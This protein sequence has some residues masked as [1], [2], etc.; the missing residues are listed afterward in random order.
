M[1]SYNS[2]GFIGKESFTAF[3]ETLGTV[4]PVEIEYSAFRGSRNLRNRPL[5]VTEYL[6]LVKRR[7]CHHGNKTMV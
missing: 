3:L 4:T 7:L 6:F 1:V 5:K 2:E